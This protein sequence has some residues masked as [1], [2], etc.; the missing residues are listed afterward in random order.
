LSAVIADGRTPLGDGDG[1]A[2]LL[3]TELLPTGARDGLLEPPAE[4]RRDV[5]EVVRHDRGAAS[6]HLDQPRG[7]VG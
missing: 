5:V 6:S 1:L 3:V 2:L 4:P 7:T